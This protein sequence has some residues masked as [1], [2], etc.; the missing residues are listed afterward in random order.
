V[1]R[2]ARAAPSIKEITET[3]MSADDSEE[4]S[5]LAKLAKSRHV[6]MLADKIIKMTAPDASPEVIADT[7]KR[8]G[9]IRKAPKT[10]AS[11]RAIAIKERAK[12][13]RDS[14]HATLQLTNRRNAANILED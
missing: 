1:D 4:A 2:S 7:K 13:L 3:R 5:L 8:L 11:L 6:I 14:Y 9:K 12:A 10:V